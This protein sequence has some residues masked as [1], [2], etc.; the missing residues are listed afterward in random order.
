MR[1]SV[2]SI[3][4]MFLLALT[5]EIFGQ[6]CPPCYFDQGHLV[7][8]HGYGEDGRQVATVYID[9]STMSNFTDEAKQ[10]VRDAVDGA[11]TGWNEATDT[12]VAPDQWNYQIQY[13]FKLTHDPAQADFIIRKGS[14]LFGCIGIDL[15]VYPHVIT[16]GDNW[17]N[18]SAAERAG[19]IKHELGH[20]LGL[21]HPGDDPNS[22]CFEGESIMQGATTLQCTGGSTQITAH[23]VA[24]S[25][26]NF[27]SP[28]TC[29]LSAP[30]TNYGVDDPCVGDPCCGDPC[31]GDP[32]CIDPNSCGGDCTWQE[33]CWQDCW[34]EWH[35]AV[36]DPCDG[37]CIQWEEWVVCNPPQCTWDCY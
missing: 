5:P 6:T 9:W 20:R 34:T 4:A 27:G 3:I 13:N 2:N 31:C 30:P 12:S 17:F 37:E 7:A 14:A 19:R 21:G 8:R 29:T 32:C 1:L 10:R 33:Y 26:R 11:M 15:S 36:S 16:F 25:N 28:N 22:N 35:C 24:K 23:D 18:S